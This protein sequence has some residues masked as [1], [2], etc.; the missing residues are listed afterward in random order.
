VAVFDWVE[1]PG[2]QLDEEP[3]VAVTRYGDGYEE[4]A[5]DG[6]NPKPQRWT[7]AFRGIERG[8]ADAIVAFFRARVDPVTGLEPFD[9]TPLW[10]SA[11]I[12]VV[13]R[14][15]TRTL[16][17]VWAEDD[18]RAVFEQVFEP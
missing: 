12:R 11:P 17:E 10:H 2:T 7:L 8:V 14:S 5:A 6:L 13:C 18:V 9:W 16:G 3:R 4:R 15:W 1:S